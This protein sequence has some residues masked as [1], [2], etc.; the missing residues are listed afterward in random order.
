MTRIFKGEYTNK[1][2]SKWKEL[3]EEE[4]HANQ[5]NERARIKQVKNKELEMRAK[6]GL[7]GKTA[8]VKKPK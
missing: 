5:A 7:K 2:I 1:I 8:K 6:F 4:M 3:P